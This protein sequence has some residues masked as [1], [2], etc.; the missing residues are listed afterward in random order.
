V[1]QTGQSKTVKMPNGNRVTVTTG[2]DRGGYYRKVTV[3]RPDG[4]A[5]SRTDRR[6]IGFLNTGLFDISGGYSDGIPQWAG[7]T[8]REWSPWALFI[9][10]LL[11]IAFLG[12]PFMFH[13]RKPVEF[14]VAAVWWVFLVGV[15]LRI[16]S[17]KRRL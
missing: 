15:V 12:W 5:E 13:W 10:L 6:N 1:A 9:G 3:R 11:V 17:Q 14:T 7:G 16:A 2:H 4:T 8:H